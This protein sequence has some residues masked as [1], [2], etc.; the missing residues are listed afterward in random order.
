MS[1]DE[2]MPK[3]EEE[4]NENSKLKLIIISKKGKLD[5]SNEGT[6]ITLKNDEGRMELRM[7]NLSENITKNKIDKTLK[8]FIFNKSISDS[9]I[10]NKNFVIID[11]QSNNLSEREKCIKKNTENN[12][13]YEIYIENHP[14]PKRIEEKVKKIGSINDFHDKLKEYESQKEDNIDSDENNDTNNNKNNIINNNTNIDENSA[15][16]DDIVFVNNNDTNDINENNINKKINKDISYIQDNVIKNFEEMKQG[17]SNVRKKEMKTEPNNTMNIRRNKI[18]E[19]LK[20][21][22][23]TNEGDDEDEIEECEE[24]I[25]SCNENNENKNN[26]LSS[27]KDLDSNIAKIDQSEKDNKYIISSINE[28]MSNFNKFFR[29]NISINNT[30]N[31]NIEKIINTY[32]ENESE[33][34]NTMII[35]E[36]NANINMSDRKI[37]KEVILPNTMSL[38]HL[39][40]SK[41]LVHSKNSLINKTN[42]IENDNNNRKILFHSGF[43]VNNNHFFQIRQMHPIYRMCS[44]C[45]NSFPIGKI[46]VSE[47]S[48]HFICK[49]CAK[50]YFEEQIENGETDL[51]C[52]FLFCKKKFAKILTKNFI[53]EEH[54]LL[55]EKN[56]NKSNMILAKVKSNINY[57]K[58]K[59]YSKNNVIDINN[60]KILFNFN[61]SKDIF[62]SKCKKD[63]L[64][65]K[66]NNY[67]LKCLN[68]GHCEC[69]YCFKDYNREHFDINSN[70]HCKVYYRRKDDYTQINP[71]IFF[72]LQSFLVFAIFVMIYISIFLN[73]KLFFQNIFRIYRNK[74]NY[75]LY[76]FKMFFAIFVSFI[77]LLV[78]FPFIFIF[79]PYFPYILATCDY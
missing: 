13:N 56:N 18:I 5:K 44:I 2:I 26:K 78:I 58:M 73:T 11:K 32:K 40:D 55:L 24:D 54:Y 69:K 61:K 74:N 72:L 23:V 77:V 17:N 52:P 38:R 27:Y 7:D 31:N 47:C 36:E 70:A 67:F 15:K 6:V 48:I 49:K 8:S 14:D 20:K 35:P 68:C 16:D 71:F 3:E 34:K 46:Y 63:A 76:Y 33:I 39:K 60:N 50:N 64:F 53:S 75:C 42:K 41:E 51:H 1:T 10:K 66:A 4:I 25:I 29:N 21:D 22:G 43:N 9:K 45:E 37:N 30:N 62:C 57:E 65:S 59:L 79:Y 12:K 28:G 19:L